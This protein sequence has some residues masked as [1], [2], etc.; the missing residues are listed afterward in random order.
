LL[1]IIVN[2]FAFLGLIALLE[3]HDA[4]LI[5]VHAYQVSGTGILFWVVK[6]YF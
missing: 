2:P 6:R 4:R 3:V 1:E 5:A